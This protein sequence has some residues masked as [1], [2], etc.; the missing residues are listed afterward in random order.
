MTVS[1]LC[2]LSNESSAVPHELH[3][4]IVLRNI[5]IHGHVSDFLYWSH[6]SFRLR[7]PAFI[8]CLSTGL[9][10]L[11]TAVIRDTAYATRTL[12]S[13]FYRMTQPDLCSQ[14]AN[15]MSDSS[16]FPFDHIDAGIYI[17]ISRTPGPSPSPSRTIHS[18]TAYGPSLR[19]L[20]LYYFASSRTNLL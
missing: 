18:I 6:A 8:G 14:T 1:A 19:R 10:T 17:F 2:P 3:K 12:S 11:C 20:L 4:E 13:R 7:P 5:G 15:S 16:L 9:T